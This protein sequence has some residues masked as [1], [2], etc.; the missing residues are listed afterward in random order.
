MR[1]GNIALFVSKKRF[2]HR[3][4]GEKELN[5]IKYIKHKSTRKASQPN[6]TFPRKFSFDKCFYT[7]NKLSLVGYLKNI[8]RISTFRA[9][10]LS[11]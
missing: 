7:F 1:R 6:I 4:I 8:R 10:A 11:Y 5:E 9:K 2:K 3:L